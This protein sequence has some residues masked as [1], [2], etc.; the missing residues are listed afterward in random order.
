MHVCLSEAPPL[1]LSFVP[2]TPCTRTPARPLAPPLLIYIS[3]H[4]STSTP[5]IPPRTRLQLIHILLLARQRL[6]PRLLT[7]RHQ[8]ARQHPEKHEQ[9][10]DLHDAVNPGC[11]I[12]MRR[13]LLDHRR[14]EYLRKHRAEFAHACAESVPRAAHSRREDFRGRDECRGIGAE[15]EEEL[16]EDVQG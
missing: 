14:E 15:V 4:A 13:A 10:E 5:S 11:R 12:I 16:R 7:L 8:Q 9:R 6:E 2:Y 3:S 1:L